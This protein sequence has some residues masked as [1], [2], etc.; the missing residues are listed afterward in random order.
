ML[1]LDQIASSFANISS[2]DKEAFIEAHRHPAPTSIRLNK[3]KSHDL[4]KLPFKCE[5]CVPW[6]DTGYYVNEKPN[7]SHDPLWHAGT[8]YVQEASSMFIQWIAHYILKESIPETILDACAAPGGK[9]QMLANTFNTS[10]IFAN[11]VS[12]GRLAILMENMA[13]QSYTNVIISS[14]PIYK[15]NALKHCF[16]LVLLDAPC[17]GSGLFRKLPQY[18]AN[19][20]PN[21]IQNCAKTQNQLINQLLPTIAPQGYLIYATCAL[22]FEENEAQILNIINN[23]PFKVV[24]LNVPKNFNICLAEYHEQCLGYRFY[25]Y[26]VQGEG[27]F[28]SLLKKDTT[29]DDLQDQFI[30]IQNSYNHKNT[31]YNKPIINSI[32][33]QIKDCATL[34]I[35]NSYLAINTKSYN[36]LKQYAPLIRPNKYGLDLGTLV[37]NKWQPS[38]EICLLKDYLSDF[39][40]IQLNL[41]QCLCYLKKNHFNLP[42]Q[43]K[44]GIKIIYYNDCSIGSIKL[45]QGKIKNYYPTSWRLRK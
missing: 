11:E 10:T 26:Q 35:N 22:S 20:N 4:T 45:S 6:C 19:F 44:D 28:V 29:K 8:Y 42:T 30:P 18:I 25:P 17:S 15:L 1:K 7:F 27:F 9:T 36:Y 13:K 24:N 34:H 33:P 16:D 38:H 31:M 14:Q 43:Y 3:L 12:S 2:F 41:E 40:P 5:Q 37:D 21:F 32:L 39:E 23:H